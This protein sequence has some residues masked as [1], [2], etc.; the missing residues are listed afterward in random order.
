M[1]LTHGLWQTVIGMHGR[2]VGWEVLD[3]SVVHVDHGG[4]SGLI[5]GKHTVC[6]EVVQDDFS[7]EGQNCKQLS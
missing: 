4:L 2:P 3:G 6:G 5:V 7:C 1:K